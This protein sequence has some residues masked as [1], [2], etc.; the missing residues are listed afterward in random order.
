M[1]PLLSF[2]SHA[3]A[4]SMHHEMDRTDDNQCVSLCVRPNTV[5]PPRNEAPVREDKQTPDPNPYAGLPYY[6]HVNLAH[7]AKVQRPAPQYAG[8]LIRP[9][10]IRLLTGNFRF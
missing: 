8:R 2:G 3:S 4:A 9:P 6:T 10:D 7:L 1:L 5:M